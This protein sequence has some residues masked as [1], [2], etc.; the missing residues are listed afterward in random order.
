MSVDLYAVCPC[1]NGKKI[2][3]CKCKDS[4][5]Q[6]DQ[7]L[8]MIEGGQVVPG[9]DR[10]KSILE[11]HPDA[12]WALAIRGRLLLDLREYD[13]LSEN[14]ERF[15]RLQPSNPLALTQRAAALVFSQDVQG[16]TDSLLEALNESGQEVDAFLM[17][18]ALIVAMGLAQSGVILSA[19]VYALLAISSQG[20]EAEQANAFLAQLDTSPGVNHLLKSVPQLIERD[21]DADW[22]ERYDEAV[23]LLRSNKVLLA[24]DKF[25]SLRRTAPNQAAILSG[26]FHCA[27]WRGDLERQTEMANQLSQVEALDLLTR[28]R[29][30]AISG[31]LSP[32]GTL[33]VNAQTIHVE[34]DDIDQA[35]MAL[36]AS[37][38]TEQLSAQ[39]LSQL[40]IPEGEVRPRS[41]FFVSDRPLESDDQD[42]TAADCPASIALVAVFGRQ[43]D[44]S[45][46]AIAFDVTED[47]VETVKGILLAAIPDGKVV[48]DEP[49]PIPM[50]FAL[51][52]RPIRQ[53][54]PKSM[55]E[56][57]RFNREFAAR[58]DGKRACELP[59]PMLAGKSLAGAADDDALAIERATVVRVL[60]GHERIISLAGALADIY[61]ISKVDPL[62]EL[63]PTDETLG[64]LSA[65][66]FFRVNPDQ[67]SPMQL[68]VLASNARA[69]GGM[70][71]CNR[72]AAKLVEKTAAD[73]ANEQENRMAMEGYILWMM[74]TPEPGE[75]IAISDRAIQFAKTHK[76]NF[77]SI[78]LARL[79]LCLSMSDQDGF[80]Q[81]IMD[82]EKNYGN[83]PSVMARVQQLLMQL[84]IIRPDGSL[85]DGPA[86]PAAA[87]TEFTPAAPPEERSG[88]VWTPD[89]PA[90]PNPSGGEGG[91]LWVPGMD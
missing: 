64:D 5:G 87:P 35:E 49:H 65:A 21:A 25:E 43:T 67:L 61:Q 71:A 8:T 73:A 16:A 83:D 31:L 6:M 50:S 20:Y 37:D 91:K 17:D 69:T 44:R 60:E 40:Q 80:R 4:V 32:I 48:L 53:L 79:E 13:S 84:G 18:V 23:G 29:Y 2:K 86:A 75:S 19:R 26:L 54:Q 41:A 27:V 59:L 57:A 88:G 74:S 30:R 39:R 58:H 10:L 3:F 90:A 76:L 38:R 34:F 56:L 66:D 24:Q 22:G 12:A 51:D 77:A 72:F 1:G 42:V 36:I 63:Q 55:A 82:I 45:A 11:E 68:Y 47:R 78:L 89:S 33:S 14:A 85:R 9:L 28:Q 70:T 15:I 81:T 52:D 46:Q 62:P 7:V